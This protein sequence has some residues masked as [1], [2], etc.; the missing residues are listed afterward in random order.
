MNHFTTLKFQI[1]TALMLVIALF[2]GVFLLS[3]VEFEVQRRHNLLLNITVR[4]DQ[5]AHHL[6][7]L[8]MSYALH[9][10][11]ESE[12]YN[13]D[14]KLYYKEILSSIK[15]FDDITMG[16]MSANFDPTLMDEPV[17][18]KP[19]LDKET[20]A[21]VNAVEDI[22]IEFRKG[23][24]KTLGSDAD[25]PHLNSAANYIT[26][27]HEPLDIAIENLK[28]RIRSLVD[29]RIQQVKVLHWLMFLT[30]IA[31]TSG[32]LAWF[33]IAVLRPLGAAA[34]G[35]HRVAQGDF[36]F[37]VPAKGN[38]EI[39]WMTKSFNQ[40]TSRLHALFL[41]ID[42]IQQGS[43][44]NETLGFVANQFPSL[45]PLDW[46]GAIFVT[47]DEEAVTLEKSYRDSKPE[48]SPRRRFRLKET[49]LL[50]TLE[51]GK[52]LHIPDM[53]HTAA[54]NPKYEFLNYLVEKGLR[55]AI[56]LPVTDRTPIKSVI[57]FA[58]SRADSYTSEH[59]ELLTNIASLVTHS[60]GQTVKL[61][62]HTRLAAIGSFASGIAHEIRSPLSTIIM[63]L[64]YLEKSNLTD[65]AS[66]RA[67]LAHREVKRLERLLEDILLYAKPLTLS[68]KR[69]NIN[70]LVSEM[71]ETYNEITIQRSQRLE[72]AQQQE[73]IWIM[74]DS[75]RLRQLFLNLMSNACDA[76]MEG[77]VIKWELGLN[78]HNHTAK[79][80]ISNPGK[81]IS[82]DRLSRI[83]DPFYT[84]KT[85]GTGLGL[86]IAKRVVEAHS[87]EIH[88]QSSETTEIRVTVMLP[89]A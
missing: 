24:E 28:N 85:S 2:A 74:G 80:T 56:F 50:Q 4:L 49:L 77:S 3:N 62:E 81:S 82:P 58:T 68:L 6:I 43:D 30:V 36:G 39:T 59:L 20:K 73:G 8:G 86:S 46:V 55:D 54:D 12:S 25:M 48:I 33:M 42:Q 51:S 57:A 63:A 88:V 69:I 84:T 70:E 17:A 29:K 65:S 83:F 32:I 37:Q 21:A 31:I 52:P 19:K 13:R 40:L 60:F 35:F 16:F 66:K 79:V 7:S 26:S 61:A 44:L 76:A 47:A 18:F 14:I 41:L 5:T 38:N 53:L 22:W 11:E 45:L 67:N 78:Q 87:G 75:D 10:P 15:L 89:L 1:A 64:D 23:L 27:N 9:P 34:E 72:I 71:V